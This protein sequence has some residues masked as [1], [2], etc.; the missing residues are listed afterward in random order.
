MTTAEKSFD[1]WPAAT[2]AAVADVLA[3]TVDG[4]S[5]PEIGLLLERI[6]FADAD[7]SNKRERLTRA[8]LVR[9]A[10]DRV[11]NCVVR[12]VTEAMAPVR[13]ARQPGVI[14][15]RRDDLNEVLVLVGLRLT[16]AGKLARGTA[17]NT[18]DEAV[19]HANS[20]RA[21]IR[22]RGTHP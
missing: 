11:S 9:Q 16:D 13:Y 5:G 3:E 1:S 6:G 8:L 14:C 7:G 22:W 12:F 10:R 17:A 15:R 2:V 21:E 18:L 19:R 20:L 4:L